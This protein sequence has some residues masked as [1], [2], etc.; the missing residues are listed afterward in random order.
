MHDH[1]RAAGQSGHE[2]QRAD[3]AEQ[4]GEPCRQAGESKSN[5]QQPQGNCRGDERG[6]QPQAFER[7]PNLVSNGECRDEPID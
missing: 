2:E 7:S 5:S 4:C 6:A 3:N 1:R